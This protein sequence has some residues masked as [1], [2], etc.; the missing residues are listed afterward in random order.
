M[1]IVKPQDF[2]DKYELSVGMYSTNKLTAYITKYTERYLVNLMGAKMFQQFEADLLNDVPRSPNF[3]EIFDPFNKDC[4]GLKLGGAYYGYRLNQ[5]LE[6]DGIH[7][8]LLGFIYWEYAR[9]L[10]N[11]QTPYGGVK[12]MA[13]NSIVVDTPHSLMWERYNL[14]V[15]TYQAIQELIQI[16]QGQPIGQVV[17]YNLTPG[18]GY[19]DGVYSLTGGSGSGASIDATTTGSGHIQD[20]TFVDAGASY[21]VGDLLTVDGGDLNATLEVT[22]VGVGSFDNF[23][24]SI[25]LRAYWL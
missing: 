22:Y 16:N 9:D 12:Q 4:D 6:S 25:K 8:M 23:N 7:E 1:A 3:L 13:E 24:G 5:I 21:Q 11:Q 14:A 10:L 19:T 20:L 17:E 15:K 18:T 2:I